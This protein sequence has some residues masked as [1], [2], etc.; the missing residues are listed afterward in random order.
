MQPSIDV[1][2]K[3]C[4]ENM[5]QIYKRT[6]MPKYEFNKVAKQLY[7]NHTSALV[8]SCTGWLLLPFIGVLVKSYSEYM[9]QIYRR[10]TMSKYCCSTPMRTLM[11][12]ENT[13]VELAITHCYIIS[14]KTFLWKTPLEGCTR[15]QILFWTESLI[16]I[17]NGNFLHTFSQLHSPLKTTWPNW[18]LSSCSVTLFS[19][20]LIK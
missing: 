10:K 13:H 5:Q 6:S 8:F 15:D 20:I 18:S 4:S 3:W 12:E 11:Q 14:E 7:W 9:Q 1:L 2:K 17:S 19:S 16:L